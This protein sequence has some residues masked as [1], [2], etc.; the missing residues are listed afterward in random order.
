MTQDRGHDW[1]PIYA[2]G[3]RVRVI[4]FSCSRCLLEKYNGRIRVP[5]SFART[6]YI[7]FIERGL[8]EWTVSNMQC[9]EISVQMVMDS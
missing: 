8:I 4:G 9:D 3:M 6:P 7:G 2:N 1:K 5:D